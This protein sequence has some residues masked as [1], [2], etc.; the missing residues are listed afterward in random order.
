MANSPSGLNSMA[1]QFKMMVDI[2]RDTMRQDFGK[3]GAIFI[4]D[5]SPH[6]DEYYAIQGIS[7]AGIDV[8]GCTFETSMTDFDA[9]FVVPNGAIIYGHF[10]KITL[11]GG[12]CI[13]Y[14]K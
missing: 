8:S 14:K 6:V 4:N 10:S 13:A 7:A 2:L 5:T 3:N 1:P 11:T 9:D 12:S